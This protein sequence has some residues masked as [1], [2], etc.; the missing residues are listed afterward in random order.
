MKH[1]KKELKENNKRKKI[2]KSL[3]GEIERLKATNK[4]KWLKLMYLCMFLSIMMIGLMWV[5]FCITILRVLN[6][7]V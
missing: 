3:Y 7:I 2:W 1:P 4:V 6:I 5:F